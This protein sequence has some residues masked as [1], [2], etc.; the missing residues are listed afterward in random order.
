MNA[1]ALSL[2]IDLIKNMGARRGEGRGGEERNMKKNMG[3]ERRQEERGDET[4][5]GKGGNEKTT[6]RGTEMIEVRNAEMMK[7]G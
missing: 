6:K 2:Q 5:K 4:R 3:R 7:R 1:P